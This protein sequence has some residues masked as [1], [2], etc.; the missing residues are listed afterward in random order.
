MTPTPRNN[1]KVLVASTVY[2]YED[3][4]ASIYALLDNFGYDVLNSHIGTIYAG[5]DKSNKEN[6]LAAVAE[7]DVFLG[8]IRPAYGS[9]VIGETSITHEEVLKAILLKKARWFLVDYKVVFARQLLRNS[10]IVERNTLKPI[11]LENIII[12]PNSFL[13]VRSI[14]IY[15]LVT[16]DK[17]PAA[18]RTGHWAQE[19]N[20]LPDMLRYIQGQFEDSLKVQNTINYMKGLTP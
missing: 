3:Q 11:K 18:E 7:C 6:C 13:D 2:G 20:D 14:E 8:I 19:Y 9:G 4:L 17:I 5:A 10:E 1:I 15:N 12:R 16:K